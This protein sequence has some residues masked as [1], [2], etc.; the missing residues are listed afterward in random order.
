MKSVQ[1]CAGKTYRWE[2]DTRFGED[3]ETKGGDR[4]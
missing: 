4:K 2:I 1:D 3:T